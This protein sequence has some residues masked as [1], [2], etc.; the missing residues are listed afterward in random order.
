MALSILLVVA[1]MA[2]VPFSLT[3]TLIGLVVRIAQEFLLLPL[4]F[5]SA[6]AFLFAAIALVLHSRIWLEGVSTMRTLD[7]SA[8]GRPP[9]DDNHNLLQPAEK[10]EEERKNGE[11]E[12]FCVR[13][14]KKRLLASFSTDQDG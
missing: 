1:G 10:A 2:L 11:V 5:S 3:V 7:S 8:H 12:G 4:P 9:G 13:K 6:L 14:R